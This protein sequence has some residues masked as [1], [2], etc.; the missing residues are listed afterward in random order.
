MASNKNIIK[1]PLTLKAAA[2][3][4]LDHFVQQVVTIHNNQSDDDYDERDIVFNLI[5]C[6]ND[7]GL[8]TYGL[9]SMVWYRNRELDLALLFKAITDLYS[10][11]TLLQLCRDE[12]W[13]DEDMF[14]LSPIS[15]PYYA[16]I[17]IEGIYQFMRDTIF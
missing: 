14:H 6:D 13:I 11:D 16:A 4:T 15:N 5:D 10:H 3:R 7:D 2:R 17:L 12:R 8:K 1:K 9:D